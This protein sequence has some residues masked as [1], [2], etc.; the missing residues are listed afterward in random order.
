MV[1]EPESEDINVRFERE[2][3]GVERRREARTM[4]PMVF[5]VRWWEKDEKVLVVC[6]RGLVWCMV[7]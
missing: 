4:G 3:D 1:E 2:R 5:V 7:A 6:G